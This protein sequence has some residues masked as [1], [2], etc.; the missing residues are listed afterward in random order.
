MPL[1]PFFD[2]AAVRLLLSL[3]LQGFRCH[4]IYAATLTPIFLDAWRA[5]P[6]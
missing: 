3:C 5:T 6:V 4:T 1:L 2:A